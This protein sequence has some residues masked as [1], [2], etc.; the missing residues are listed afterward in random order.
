[1]IKLSPKQQQVIELVA[2]GLCDKEIGQKLNIGYGTVRSHMNLILSK[3]QANNR[4]HAIAIWK[5]NQK[6][7]NDDLQIKNI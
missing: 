3:L 2:E 1:M 6:I 5:D 7:C 4:A